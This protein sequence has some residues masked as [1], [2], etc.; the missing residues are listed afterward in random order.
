M[1]RVYATLFFVSAGSLAFQVTL[2]R[3]FSLAQWYHFAFMAISLALLGI[4][5]SGSFLHIAPPPFRKRL[6]ELVPWAGLAFSASVLLSYLAAN[7]IPFDSYRIA[8]DP[9]QYLYLLAYFLA[10]SLPFFWS[11]FAVGAG[12]A[13]FPARSST[14][15]AASLLGSALGCLMPLAAMPAVGGEGSVAICAFLGIPGWFL[16][17]RGK[18]KTLAF[19][20]SL[21]L[22]L[23]ALKPP[24]FF[25]I[26]LSPYKEL[27]QALNQKGTRLLLRRWN[28]FSRVD[29]AEMPSFHSA[30]GLSLSFQG[31]IPPQKAIFIDGGD[32][33][34][35][36]SPSDLD[37]LE[38]TPSLLPYLLRPHARVLILES[39]GGLEVLTALRGG[40]ER[41]TAVEGNP[42]VVWA[43]DE[44]LGGF[45]GR[46][47]SHPSVKAVEV[48]GRSF[49]KGT[50]EKYDLIIL[51]LADSRRVITSGA[52]SLS[53]NY[54]YTLEAF[55]DYLAHLTGNGIL[56]VH[57]W[58]QVPP[59]ESLKV[60]AMAVKALERMKVRDPASHLVAL[61]SWSTVTVLVG[62]KPFTPEEI[63]RVKAFCW[64]RFDLVYYKGMREEEANVY[65]VLPEPY[66][67]RAFVEL[68]ERGDDFIRA[69]P[70]DISPP[71]DD[72]PF[73]FHFFKWVQ[74]PYI[75]RMMGKVWM[76]FGGSGY[77]VLLILLGVAA[78]AALTLILLPL[79]L[80]PVQ[81]WIPSGVWA[82][83][84][85]YFSLLGVGYIL[86]EVPLIQ[87]FILFLDR[88][89]YAFSTV[90]ASLL[91]SS[92]LGS[93]LSGRVPWR[94]SLLA[95]S[96]L[97]FAY[98]WGLGKALPAFMGLP[99]ALRL[100]LA[101]LLLSPLGF[102]MGIPF[103]RGIGEVGK[104]W[105][106]L[107]PWAWGVNGS[108]SVVSS[109]GAA[110]LALSFGFRWVLAG[111]SLAYLGALLAQRLLEGQK[112]QDSGRD[113]SGGRQGEDGPHPKGCSQ[114]A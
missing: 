48:E 52:Y 79:K 66:H 28:A 56:V 50:D 36:T 33:S 32:P 26:R 47:Y 58:F 110:I 59:S 19:L 105:P 74:T 102:L 69:Y 2:T 90:V 37:F 43:A 24:S 81:G 1:G 31:R 80:A 17:L 53:E 67:Y 30:P 27:S 83:V 11:G 12:L 10:I 94:F 54:L 15:Y 64:G 62:K 8:W 71:T 112:G 39:R 106:E 103:P 77:L 5:A 92:G 44:F 20:P 68:L 93:F 76:P 18:R 84:L 100:L 42:L 3:L 21:L 45:S 14:L 88:P 104:R 16:G 108:L 51:S 13:S 4:G 85:A 55:E 75:F 86:V 61:R 98:P 34:P 22:I 70:F 49:L 109:I 41:V 101:V 6:P 25:E 89:V 73:F 111:G 114:K 46:I 78:F 82:G 60:A 63:E 65:N 9:L 38:H 97:A 57:R 96:L 87:K 35:V 7:F 29:V 113:R 40:A 95:I 99:L 72:R 91:V 107:V 23:L